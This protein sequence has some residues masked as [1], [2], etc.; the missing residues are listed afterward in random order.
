M[1]MMMNGIVCIHT[2][3]ISVYKAGMCEIKKEKKKRQI[4]RQR[5]S[6][7][8]R[9]HFLQVFNNLTSIEPQTI[10]LILFQINSISFFSFH[11]F[12]SIW[13]SLVLLIYK[14]ILVALQLALFIVFLLFYFVTPECITRCLQHIF[15][16]TAT[17]VP[18]NNK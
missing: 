7:Y 13:P 12:I 18:E 10:Y 17:S 3:C 8:F 6:E 1:M 5:G 11:I 2:L 14:Y 9:R 4:E 15:Y 16:M